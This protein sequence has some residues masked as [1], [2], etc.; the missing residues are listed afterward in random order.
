MACTLVGVFGDQALTVRLSRC[1]TLT[2]LYLRVMRR[3]NVLRT[4][5]LKKIILRMFGSREFY[6]Y[7]IHR[8]LASEKIGVG[9]S[10][11]YRV[12]TEMLRDGWLEARWEKG[13]LGPRRRVYRIGG[14]GREEREKI[15]LA[16]INTVHGFYSEYLLALPPD[17]NVLNSVC[18]VLINSVDRRGEL[19]YISPR[20]SV[21]HE[22]I[23]HTL[24]DEMPEARICFVKPASL[25]VNLNF[26]NLWF[27]NGTCDSIPLRDGYVDLAIVGEVPERNC[28]EKSLRELRRVLKQGGKL[29]MIVPTVLMRRYD[30][31]LSIGNFI[32]KYEHETLEKGEYLEARAFKGLLQNLFDKVEEKQVVHMTVFLASQP[33][34]PQRRQRN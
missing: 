28:L 4:E 23:L 25:T 26:D 12:L 11:L 21:M 30:D 27:L 7:E 19:A 13:R 15:L 9:I 34:F 22:R 1:G 17:A 29:A 3:L 5:D 33:H 2:L 31:P 10:R 24:H 18:R 14:K 20:C 6:G 16:A 32:E 8:E